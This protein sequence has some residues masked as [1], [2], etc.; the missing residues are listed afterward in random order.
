MFDPIVGKQWELLHPSDAQ[1]L[2]PTMELN[3]EGRQADRQTDV[4]SP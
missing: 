1:Q 2:I 4:T 3:H